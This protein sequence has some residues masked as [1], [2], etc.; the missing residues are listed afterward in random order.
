[1]ARPPRICGRRERLGAQ[2]KA[3]RESLGWT[4]KEL[5][6][7]L[8][9]SRALVMKYEGRMKGQEDAVPPVRYLHKVNALQRAM[10]KGLT[11][12]AVLVADDGKGQH[13]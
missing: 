6:L 7:A 9:C 13:V 3:L 10:K 5:A 8:N 2:L 1:M 4:E 12:A 11:N